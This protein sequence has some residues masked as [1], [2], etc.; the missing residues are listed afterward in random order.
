MDQFGVYST[1]LKELALQPTIPVL[2]MNDS[3]DAEKEFNWLNETVRA[4]SGLGDRS[5][6]GLPDETGVVVL[7]IQPKGTLADAGIQPGDVI[8]SINDTSVKSI[9]DLF[10]TTDKEKWKNELKVTLFR[11]QELVEKTILLK[12]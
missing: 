9:H 12:R 10:T 6:F 3:S 1:H 7:T 11:N 8:R 5:A 2:I 4:I